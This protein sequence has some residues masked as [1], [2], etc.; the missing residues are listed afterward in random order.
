[1][2]KDSG[3]NAISHL[4]PVLCM[5]IESRRKAQGQLLNLNILERRWG[6]CPSAR[7]IY[8]ISSMEICLDHVET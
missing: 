5:D 6:R 8:K 1:M 7:R 3:T 2:R 4:P